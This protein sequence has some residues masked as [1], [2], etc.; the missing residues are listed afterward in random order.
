MY[1][2]SDSGCTVVVW[3]GVR[4]RPNRFAQGPS[5]NRLTTV[6]ENA[7]FTSYFTQYPVKEI[8]K[9]EVKDTVTDSY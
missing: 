7:I 6:G 3:G 5:L 1:I 8:R 2:V 9:E 4:D